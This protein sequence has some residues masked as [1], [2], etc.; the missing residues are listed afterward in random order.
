MVVS[1]SRPAQ[2]NHFSGEVHSDVS[3]IQLTAKNNRLCAKIKQPEPTPITYAF[4][5]SRHFYGPCMPPDALV[6]SQTLGKIIKDENSLQV[7]RY[8]FLSVS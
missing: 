3:V 8:F 6:L 4:D 5:T 2:P 1:S 7:T